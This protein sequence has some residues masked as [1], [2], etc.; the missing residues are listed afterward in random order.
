M[1][2]QAIRVQGSQVPRVGT[3][4]GELSN[5]PLVTKY[6]KDLSGEVIDISEGIARIKLEDGTESEI[7][8]PMPI[9]G[10][11]GVNISF[12]FIPKVGD[13]VKKGDPIIKPKSLNENYNLMLGVNTRVAMMTYRG[14]NYEDGV[15][16]SESFADKMSHITVQDVTIEVLPN[17]IIEGMAEVGDHLHLRSLLMTGK[18]TREKEGMSKS[19]LEDLGLNK[20]YATQWNKFVPNDVYD[21]IVYDIRVEKGPQLATEEADYFLSGIGRAI[22]YDNKMALQDNNWDLEDVNLQMIPKFK[23]S[24][25]SAYTVK[26]RLIVKNKLKLGDKL[27]NR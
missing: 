3:G 14:Y 7:K 25:K 16:V 27:T 4:N 1:C 23:A 5:N 20:K 18:M 8:I 22:S 2:T 10:N 19:F 6:T 24:S 12:E 15:I 11:N 9:K 13:Q 21:S 26:Y 17:V